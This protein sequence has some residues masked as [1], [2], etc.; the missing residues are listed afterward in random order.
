MDYRL[1][2]NPLIS[3]TDKMNGNEMSY[4]KCKNQLKFSIT[5]L[6]KLKDINF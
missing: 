6:K 4:I 5:N 1:K 2:S 3:L